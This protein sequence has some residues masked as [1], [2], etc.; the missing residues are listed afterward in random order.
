MVIS[1]A[2]LGNY[3]SMFP[4]EYADKFFYTQT[5]PCLADSIQMIN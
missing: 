2:L 4:Q 3:N 5:A 1:Y